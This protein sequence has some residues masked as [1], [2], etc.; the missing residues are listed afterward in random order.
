MKDPILI[1]LLILSCITIVIL[2]A[3]TKKMYNRFID[4]KNKFADVKKEID[5]YAKIVTE[6]NNLVDKHNNLVN[7]HNKLISEYEKVIK[8]HNNLI[9]DFNKSKGYNGYLADI[10]EYLL[11]LQTFNTKSAQKFETF[12]QEAAD[13]Y[14]V[15]NIIKKE[16]KENEQTK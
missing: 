16:V 2:Y 9:E 11:G 14:K 3:K 7:E 12:C 15:E 4:L 1:I 5:E 6:Y 10:N 13:K 8:T